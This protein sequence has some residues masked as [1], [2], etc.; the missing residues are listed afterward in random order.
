MNVVSPISNDT[1]PD[2]LA[3]TCPGC[4]EA[5]LPDQRYCLACGRPCS[6][7]RLAFLDILQPESEQRSQVSIVSAPGDHVPALQ[8]DG[9]IGWLR[10]Y[11][12][13]LALLSVLLTTGLIGLLVGHWLAPSKTLGSEVLTIRGLPVAGA[14]PPA[15]TTAATTTATTSAVNQPPFAKSTTASKPT[16]AQEV[17][18]VREA[19]SS[20]AK[21]PPPVKT[22][23]SS[24]KKVEKL[25]GKQHQKAIEALT[26]GGKPIETGG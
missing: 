1:E 24:L 12:G 6:P 15:T 19:E 21:S 7:V 22:S 17:R 11:A 2:V 23:S 8:Q 26:A 3:S 5:V 13:L 18:E 25:T 9:A 16:E 10:R 20:K 4:G 14:A